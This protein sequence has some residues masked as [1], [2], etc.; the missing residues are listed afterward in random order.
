MDLPAAVCLQ[1]RQKNPA[2][3]ESIIVSCSLK[4]LLIILCLCRKAFTIV[5]T[6]FSQPS[7][8]KRSISVLFYVWSQPANVTDGEFFAFVC[9]FTVACRGGLTCLENGLHGNESHTM[10][11]NTADQI[12]IMGQWTMRS[13]RGWGHKSLG[14]MVYK[15]AFLINGGNYRRVSKHRIV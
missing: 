5:L 11:C 2:N 9:R 4:G 6:S 15:P 13:S 10:W 14:G 3:T 8:F 1:G 12:W 7:P